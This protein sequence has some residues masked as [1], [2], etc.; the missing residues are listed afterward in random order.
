MEYDRIAHVSVL[1]TEELLLEQKLLF[2]VHDVLFLKSLA[3]NQE[4]I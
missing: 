3:V 1:H 2:F 4:L